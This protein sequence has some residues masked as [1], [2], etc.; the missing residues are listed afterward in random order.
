MNLAAIIS[1]VII[2]ILV[3]AFVFLAKKPKFPNL[4]NVDDSNKYG[5][6]VLMLPLVS[7]LV[8]IKYRNI[9]YSFF[10]ESPKIIYGI[11]VF[12]VLTFFLRKKV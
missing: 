5:L 9:N 7:W 4:L 8:F 12:F 3:M 2:F 1:G 11:L 6:L 10:N